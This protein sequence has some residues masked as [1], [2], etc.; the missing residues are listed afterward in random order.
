MGTRENLSPMMAIT[1][2]SILVMSGELFHLTIRQQENHSAL[3]LSNPPLTEWLVFVGG[4][5]TGKREEVGTTAI[6]IPKG[7]A[8]IHNNRKRCTAA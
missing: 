2:S 5:D 6:G 7:V 1:E 4:G 8:F 3:R